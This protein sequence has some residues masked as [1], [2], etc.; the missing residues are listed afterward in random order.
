MQSVPEA[1]YEKVMQQR[2]EFI[3]KF[4]NSQEELQENAT[5]VL[6]LAAQIKS[7]KEDNAE[8][9]RNQVGPHDVR[10]LTDCCVGGYE[11]RL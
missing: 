3:E 11:S 5:E 7:L 2:D 10:D 8:L 4:E 6:A 9:R 1:D